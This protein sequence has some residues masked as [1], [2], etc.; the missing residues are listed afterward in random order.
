M[1]GCGR[2]GEFHRACS[3]M[4]AVALAL[5]LAWPSNGLAGSTAAPGTD[6]RPDSPKAEAAPETT[7]KVAAPPQTPKAIASPGAAGAGSAIVPG[8]SPFSSLG[9]GNSHQPINIKSDTLAL[10][11]RDKTVQFSGHVRAMQANGELTSDT[12]KVLYGADFHDIKQM[13]ADGNVRISQGARWATGDHA[14]LN[15]AEHTVVLTGNP[16]VH[17]GNDQITG[18]RITVHLDTGK[19]VVEQARALIFP[20]TQQTP[21]NGIGAQNA[22]R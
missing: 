10:D 6:G 14:V 16:V 2:R 22:Q 18:S 11:Y 7:G 19:S 12:L 4:L 1:A 21:D 15:D 3:P 5:T 20:R 8:N 17:D 13:I 9:V